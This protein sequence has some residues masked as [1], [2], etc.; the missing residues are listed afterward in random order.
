MANPTVPTRQVNMSMIWRRLKE[1]FTTGDGNYVNEH[2]EQVYGKLPRAKL[3]NPIKTIMRPTAMSKFTPALP[4][5][6]Y[7]PY[8]YFARL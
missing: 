7:V 4:R 3:E 6:E 2:G 1:I 5:K 8:T